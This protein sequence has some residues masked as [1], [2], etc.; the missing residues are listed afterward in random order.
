[1]LG[2]ALGLAQ[3]LSRHVAVSFMPQAAS[4]SSI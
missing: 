1:M 3:W 4:V 2:C